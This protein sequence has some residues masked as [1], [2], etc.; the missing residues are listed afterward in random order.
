M[1]AKVHA[2]PI[3]PVQPFLLTALVNMIWINASEVFRYFVFIM[4]MLRE[5]FPQIPTVAPMNLG[6]F[7]I[8]G[9]W[10]TILVFATTGFAWLYLERFGRGWR[11]AVIAGTL[12]WLAIFVIL[13]LGLFNMGLATWAILMIALPL[14]WLEMVVAALIVN[15][16]MLRFGSHR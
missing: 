9:I 5:S 16:G 6:V 1:A 10:D 3:P 11:Q 8:W 4:P 7:A 13:W 14:S 12:V 15:W 2:R